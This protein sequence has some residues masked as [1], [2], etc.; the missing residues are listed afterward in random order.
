MANARFKRRKEARPAEITAAAMDAF[1]ENG[2][3][4]TRVDDVAKRAGI[5]KGLLYRYF[6]TKEDLFKAVIRGFVSPRVS[7]LTAAAESADLPVEAFLRG[8]FL[9][10]IQQV[11]H[12]PL[13]I[14]VR[15]MISEGPKHPDLTAYYWKHVI[16]PALAAVQ[17]LIDKGI[18]NGEFRDTGLREHPQLLVSPVLMA[19]VWAVVFDRHQAL[20]TDELLRTHL[21]LILDAI[22][23]RGD[24]KSSS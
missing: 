10:R 21:D 20:D 11:P 22:R 1:A 4:A 9:E 24:R 16:S 15:L 17:S 7:D 18:Q 5:S 3:D 8:P 19:T 2:Y 6:E 12:S 13:K 23:V 14:L